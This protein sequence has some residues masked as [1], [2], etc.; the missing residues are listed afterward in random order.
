MYID[1]VL[2]K[3]EGETKAELFQ[4]PRFSHLKAGD[5]VLVDTAYGEKHA[6]VINSM[7]VDPEYEEHRFIL[8]A[9]GATEPLK[10]VLSQIRYKAFTYEEEN[11]EKPDNA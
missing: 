2:C 9:T 1:L 3:V 8:D 6:K 7:S 4:A 11:D 10:R 5:D